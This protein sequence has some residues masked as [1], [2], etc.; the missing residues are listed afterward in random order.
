M[1]ELQLLKSNRFVLYVALCTVIAIAPNTYFVYYTL[2]IFSSPY[3]E[4]FSAWIA[5]VLSFSIMLYT[6][7]KNIEVA[8][9]LGYFEVV[10]AGY[11]YINKI[12]FDW[13][14]I[15]GIGFACI[16]PYTLTQ[17]A[18]EIEIDTETRAKI[19]FKSDKLSDPELLDYM[20]RNPKSTPEEFFKL[21]KNKSA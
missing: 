11:Y 5:L 1:R 13:P 4:I 10:I 7:R 20:N 14:L 18:K 16:L 21:Q 12:G 3:R 19:K 6:V 9:Y 15:P 2:S 17:Y 8:T